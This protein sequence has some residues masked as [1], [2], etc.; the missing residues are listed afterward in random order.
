MRKSLAFVVITLVFLCSCSQDAGKNKKAAAIEP[1]PISGEQLFKVNCMQ[2]HLPGKDFAGPALAG[3]RERWKNKD[4]LYE[5]VKDP[6][7]VIAK[8]DYAAALFEK[9]KQAPMTPASHL[10]N[11]EIDAILDY[12]DGEVK[13]K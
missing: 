1:A 10:S 4:L 13:A 8:D 7:A 9:W 6:Q 5:F 3:A 2:C 11:E 12:C